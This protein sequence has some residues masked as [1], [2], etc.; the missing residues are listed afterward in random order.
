M[1]EKSSGKRTEYLLEDMH[2]M[3]DVFFAGWFFD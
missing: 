3:R 2:G 1:H